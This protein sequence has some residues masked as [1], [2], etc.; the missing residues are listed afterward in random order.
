MCTRRTRTDNCG[1]SCKLVYILE[2]AFL[3]NLAG[4][5]TSSETQK[6][7]QAAKGLLESKGPAEQFVR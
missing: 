4:I 7:W 2:A 5:W 6:T 1:V 3:H